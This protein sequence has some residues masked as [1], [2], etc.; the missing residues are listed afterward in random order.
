MADI[1][2]DA[3][4]EE[5][6]LALHYTEVLDPAESDLIHRHLLGCEACQAKADEVVETLAALALLDDADDVDTLAV[7]TAGL[8]REHVTGSAGPAGRTARPA[9]RS[10]TPRPASGRTRSR[11]RRLLHTAML[12]ALVL[13]VAGLGLAALLRPSGG[14][15]NPTPVSASITATDGLSGA[16]ASIT[17]VDVA[18][19]GATVRATVNGLHAGTG[20]VLTAVD[21]DGN[22]HEVTRW[23]GSA[24]VADVSGNVPASAARLSFFTVATGNGDHVLTVY[25]PVRPVTTTR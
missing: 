4:V 11:R 21:V 6:R 8:V 25:L 22:T 12:L 18:A 9:G 23:T 16:G 17:V 20:Y 14:E 3:H 19:G 7:S 10:D 1:V 24:Q 15:E 13:M 2:G 5:E